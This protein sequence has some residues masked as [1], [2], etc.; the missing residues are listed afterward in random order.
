MTAKT[1]RQVSGRLQGLTTAELYE[2]R[3]EIDTL[4]ASHDAQ[5][6]QGKQ[7]TKLGY[8]EVKTFK[9]KLKNGTIAEYK[10]KYK[11]WVDESGKLRSKYLG[12]AEPTVMAQPKRKAAA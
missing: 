4:L 11:R 9:K 1:Y 5:A 6:K 7:K 2:L 3:K 10:Y 12:K 8:I